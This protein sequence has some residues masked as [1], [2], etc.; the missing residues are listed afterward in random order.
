MPEAER[1]LRNANAPRAVGADLR[2]IKN[3]VA[4]RRLLGKLYRRTWV[5]LAGKD[6]DVVF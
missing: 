2:F 6:F 1:K 3:L 5:S 4:T